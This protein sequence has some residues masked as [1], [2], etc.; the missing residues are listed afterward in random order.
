MNISIEGLP[1]RSIGEYYYRKFPIEVRW[2]ILPSEIYN[3]DPMGNIAI[4]NLLL[5]SGAKYYYH[6]FI[7]EI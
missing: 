1:L 2:E 5:K 7:V 3:G 6:K 4:L